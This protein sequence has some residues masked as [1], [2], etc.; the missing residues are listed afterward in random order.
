MIRSKTLFEW[1][2]VTA[3][4][5]T[6]AW[7]ATQQQWLWR[8][9]T[10]LY[11]TALTYRSV[12][13]DPD[14]VIVAIDDRSL[15]DIGRWPWSRAVHAA[16]LERLHA[17][18]ARVVVFD[19]ILHESTTSDRLADAVLAE[20]MAEH[21]RVVLPV[22]HAWHAS[23]G[24]GEGLPTSLF[25]ESAARLGHIHIELDPDGIAR[26]LY[27]WEGMHQPDYA[28]L[29]LAALQLA[30]PARAAAYPAPAQKVQEGWRRADW[31]HIP[32]LGPPGSF[33]YV[34]Y[35]DV[36][37]GQVPDAVLKDAIV[38][39]GTSAA[40]MG[41]MVPT[42]TSGHASLMPGVE[43][44]ASVYQALRHG[45]ILQRAS[46]FVTALFSLAVVLLLMVLMPR[47]R[48]RSAMLVAFGMAVLVLGVSW[49]ALSWALLWLPPSATVLICLLAY[50]LWSWRRLE[51]SR[52]YFEV[53]LEALREAVARSDGGVKAPRPAMVVDPFVERIE[54]L[55]EAAQR[56]RDMARS[57]EETLDFLSHDLRSPLA[58]ILTTLDAA[59]ATPEAERDE[60]RRELTIQ[61]VELYARNALDLAESLVRLIR[62][63]SIDPMRF[64]ELSLDLVVLDAADAAW[65]AANAKSMRFSTEIDIPDDDEHPCVVLGDADL[66]RRTVLNLLDN[67]IKYTPAGGEV[68]LLLKAVEGGWLV[69]V[70]DTGPGIAEELQQRL[71]QRFSRLPAAERSSTGGV[72]LGLLMVRTVAE[73]H[74]GRV[75]LESTPG[76]GSVFRLFLP[77]IGRAAS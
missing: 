58:S 28:Q 19:V 68:G 50:P 18:G 69:E 23:G 36:L 4:C 45:D 27:L 44:H 64:N 26:S 10:V 22:T 34:S 11:D 46:P 57:R 17:Q 51:A 47:L 67:A 20:R 38:F 77:A 40:G 15:A 76:E 73:R 54:V 63:E 3:V 52:H 37:R 35:G 33:R 1:L 16:L 74:G 59:R 30:E 48:P 41:D 62:A 29:A 31:F 71:F 24:D 56:Q 9:D 14:I 5:G 61:R 8:F 43:I 21:G 6:V 53:E 7:I 66:L 32:F 75:T 65:A 49:L 25:R 72:G 42:P 70:S 60:E 55:R 12:E 13:P 39:V 2:V